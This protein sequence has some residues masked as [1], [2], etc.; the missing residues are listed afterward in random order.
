MID[1]LSAKP[2]LSVRRFILATGVLFVVALIWNGLLHGI[3]LHDINESVSSL[4]RSDINNLIWLPLL[5]TLGVVS[6]FVWG[7]S[8][9]AREGSL[10][11][12]M[13]YGLFFGLLAG[14]LVDL[15]QYVLYPLPVTAPLAWFAGGLVEFLLYGVLVTK[16]YPIERLPKD[17]RG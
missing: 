9:M 17:V 16:L 12:G 7:Y 10:R 5:M 15:N 13:E 1:A 3:V 4:R 14:F 6:L 2:S 11:E 8:R